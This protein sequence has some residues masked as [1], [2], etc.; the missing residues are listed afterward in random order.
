MDG[1]PMPF[2]GREDMLMHAYVF[3]RFDFS[4]AKIKSCDTL[5]AENYGWTFK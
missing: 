5:G 1:T 2:C 4:D 3:A